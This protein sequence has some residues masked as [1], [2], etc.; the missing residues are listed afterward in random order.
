MKRLIFLILFFCPWLLPTMDAQVGNQSTSNSGYSKSHVFVSIDMPVRGQAQED[1]T[2]YINPEK[3]GYAYIIVDNYPNKF[4]SG[5]LKLKL[6]KKSG[7]QNEKIDEQDYNIDNTYTYTYIKYGFMT[8]GDYA[9]DVYDGNGTFI[10][11]GFVNVQNSNGTTSNP[12]AKPYSTSRAFVSIEVPVAGMANE[13][14]VIIIDRSIGS[15]AYIVLDNYP[16]NFNV[17]QINLKSYKKVNGNYEKL[18]DEM[19]DI[20]PD[21][22]FTYLKYSFYSEGEYAFDIYDK[23]KTFINTAYVSVKYK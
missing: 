19:Y 5:L 8:I 1:K 9:F 13:S 15:Y 14:K 7:G 18:G 22:F 23:N 4:A 16:N 21:R 10:N 3:G 12:D 11:S 2:I 6:Y 17:N 20:N